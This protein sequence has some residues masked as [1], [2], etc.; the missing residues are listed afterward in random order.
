MAALQEKKYK[1]KREDFGELPVKLDHL[2]IYLNFLDNFVEASNILHMTAKRPMQEIELDARDLSILKVEWMEN[3][4]REDQYSDLKYDYVEDKA[5][6][7]VDLPRE[8]KTGEVFRIRTVT[9][10]IPSDH[11]LSGLI[12]RIGGPMPERLKNGRAGSSVGAR[13]KL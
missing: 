4:N 9:Q 1:Y 10:C 12:E 11:L 7:V 2:T 8:I 13:S 3:V 6:L 5:K